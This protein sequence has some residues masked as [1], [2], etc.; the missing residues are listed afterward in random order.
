MQL[1][2]VDGVEMQSI[3]ISD[4][5]LAYGDGI[6]ETIAVK[7]NQLQLWDLHCKRIT[8]SCKI[9]RIPFD[10]YD[11]LNDEVLRCSAE[12]HTGVIK[13]IITAGDGKR[14]YR[15]PENIK[16][17]RIITAYSDDISRYDDD[18]KRGI[19]VTVCKTR[20]SNHTPAGLKHLNRLDQV[21]ARMEWN[22]EYTEGLMLDND[23]YVRE[24]TMSN[25]FMI[26][27][28]HI[29]TP[30]LDD[31]GVRGVMRESIVNQCHKAGILVEEVDWNVS[32]VLK[33]DGLFLCNSIIGILP[34]KT[35][36]EQSFD[37]S[38]VHHFIDELNSPDSNDE[39]SII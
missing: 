34:I 13:I 9:L 21:I 7:E 22:D 36:D 31:C 28:M 16:P 18:F 11:Q 15:R 23:G 24:G 27:G 5:G 38:K 37:I 20:L 1:F 32:E 3:S 25:L 39:E 4:R 12:I 19:A 2:L 14:G 30:A 33:S 8:E 35:V 10:E 6:F 29:L 17:R 26:C